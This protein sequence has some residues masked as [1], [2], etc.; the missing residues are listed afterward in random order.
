MKK[1]HPHAA[2]LA[3]FYKF[4][5]GRGRHQLPPIA[6]YAVSSNSVRFNLYL[7]VDF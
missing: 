5:S 3:A 4:L 6:I 1:V 7:V 2:G